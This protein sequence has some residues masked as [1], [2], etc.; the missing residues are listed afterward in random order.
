MQRAK[1]WGMAKKRSHSPEAVRLGQAIRRR[2]ENLKLSQDVFADIA[3]MHRSYV[4]FVERGEQN[5]TLDTMTKIAAALKVSLAVLVK[6]AG[7]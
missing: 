4:G 7:I 3:G 6:E 5:L 2:R 1:L